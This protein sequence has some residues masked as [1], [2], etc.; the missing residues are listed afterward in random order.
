MVRTSGGRRGQ[1]IAV[2][3]ASAVAS[4]G[5]IYRLREPQTRMVIKLVVPAVKQERTL[6]SR[7]VP[8]RPKPGP[9]HSA[10]PVRAVR[11]W[12]RSGAVCLLTFSRVN[13][14]LF[15]TT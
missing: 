7:A 8:D 1:Q 3:L 5:R 2:R 9:G 14:S 11:R 15:D 6:R 12:T 4:W 13:S 10:P